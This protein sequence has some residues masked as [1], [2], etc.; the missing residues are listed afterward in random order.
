MNPTVADLSVILTTHNKPRFAKEAVQSL[1]DQTH[2]NWQ[3]VLV[4]SGVL[5]SQ[6]FFEYLSDERLK[7][8]PSGET[9][10]L[11]RTTNMAS[12][13]FNR[14]LNSGQLTGELVMYLNDDDLLYPDA[15]ATYWAFYQQHNREP[16]A[17]YASQDVGLVDQSGKTRVIGHRVANRPAGRACN[18]RRLDCR[19]DYL[20]FCHTARILEQFRQTYRTTQYHSEDKSDS[21]HADGI[22]MEQIGALTKIYNIDKVLSMNRRTVQS[23]NI[24]YAASPL[25][26][27]LAMLRAKFRGAR[28]AWFAPP[29]Y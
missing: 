28:E 17:M 7:V 4:D 8:V 27:L 6:G 2:R 14:V 24:E 29:R 12:W 22:F 1:L 9:P 26:R 23:A 19:V 15:F 21:H 25:G 11:A 5:L 13:C 10:D 3:G 18:G 16:Q 20:Q